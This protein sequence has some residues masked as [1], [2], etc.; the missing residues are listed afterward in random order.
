MMSHRGIF[1]ILILSAGAVLLHAQSI[2]EFGTLAGRSTDAA[3]G[4]GKAGQS[5]VDVFGKV[6]QSLTGAG[7]V[8]AA[9]KPKPLPVTA[10]PATTIAV[11]AQAKPEPVLPPDLSA[12]AIG[13]DRADM[14]KKVGKPRMSIS[15]VEDATLIETCTYRSGSDT[16]TVTLRDGKVAVIAGLE[17]LAAKQ[18]LAPVNDLISH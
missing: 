10:A 14:V 12:L 8:D 15:S 9:A 17:N 3:S 18:A 1:P 2:V 11:A 5:I 4:A 16:V 7:A 6:T 13:M